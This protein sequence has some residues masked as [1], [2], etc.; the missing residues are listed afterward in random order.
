MGLTFLGDGPIPVLGRNAE[1]E[2]GIWTRS[3]GEPEA[4]NL[5]VFF[6]RLSQVGGVR[7][8]SWIERGKSN[9]ALFNVLAYTSK[10]FVRAYRAMRNE[11]LH[12]TRTP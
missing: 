10:T 8:R 7:P 9:N 12:P 2:R 4:G 1:A 11:Q 6:W 5:M 3:N